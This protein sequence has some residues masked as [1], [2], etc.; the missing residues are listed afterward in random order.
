[1]KKKYVLKKEYFGKMVN[2]IRGKHILS[3]KLSQKELK[4]LYTTGHIE[5]I[6]IIEYARKPKATK[7][8]ISNF[9]SST[10][11]DGE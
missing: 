11:T 4:D 1:M 5:K 10:P 6:E 9:E 3:D 8:D 2:D 7:P